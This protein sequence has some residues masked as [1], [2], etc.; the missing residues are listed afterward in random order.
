MTQQIDYYSTQGN[1]RAVHA[2]SAV[3]RLFLLLRMKAAMASERR[4]MCWSHPRADE[5]TP[6]T[7]VYNTSS[8]LQLDTCVP[9]VLPS[10]SFICSAAVQKYPESGTVHTQSRRLVDNRFSYSLFFAPATNPTVDRQHS[11]P[12]G[13]IKG[14]IKFTCLS[15]R[16][17][18]RSLCV[19]LSRLLDSELEPSFCDNG[20]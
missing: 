5:T 20:K 7:L 17:G 12:V 18:S 4:G 19:E 2:N 10:T 15:A 3:S 1:E 9:H 14:P 6:E 8:C 13:S 16:G 11:A